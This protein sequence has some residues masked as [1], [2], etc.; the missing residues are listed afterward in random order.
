ME[1]RYKAIPLPRSPNETQ[2]Y[3]R[4]LRDLAEDTRKDALGRL[5][6]PD[7]VAIRTYVEKHFSEATLQL[8]ELIVSSQAQPATFARRPLAAGAIALASLGNQ[9]PG[10]HDWQSGIR[11]AAA[12]ERSD[13]E[14]QC[15]FNKW[16]RCPLAWLSRVLRRN[17]VI[18]EVR[19]CGLP[20][21]PPDV[22][23]YGHGLESEIVAPYSEPDNP[24]RLLIKNLPRQ[25]LSDKGCRSLR[26]VTIGTYYYLFSTLDKWES[27]DT[28][29]P[30][31]SLTPKKA[32]TIDLLSKDKD[33]LGKVEVDCNPERS[34]WEACDP[35]EQ[36]CRRDKPCDL[37]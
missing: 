31:R 28:L 1:H 21:Q 18:T 20:H 16:V 34:F 3:L 22:Y 10:A 37:D 19:V 7:A 8:E 14:G 2:A 4:A 25:E 24:L 5:D 13:K 33:G 11:L 36:P 12:D 15:R 9:T 23:Y 6:L 35:L 32:P 17:G 30:W 27:L 26:S 29:E